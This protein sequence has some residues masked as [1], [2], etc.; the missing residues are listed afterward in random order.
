MIDRS[1]KKI[2]EFEAILIDEEEF[3]DWSIKGRIDLEASDKHGK[4]YLHLDQIS[5]IGS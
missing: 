3:N 4:I 2:W 1:D 5:S